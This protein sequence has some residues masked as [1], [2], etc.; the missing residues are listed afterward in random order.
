MSVSS[1]QEARAEGRFPH[2]HDPTHVEVFMDIKRG[3]LGKNGARSCLFQ[4][5][6][7][8]I[9]IRRPESGLLTG[10]TPVDDHGNGFSIL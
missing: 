6:F 10:F 1:L 3:M 7:D 8:G 5:Q 4:T 9:Q 2:Y